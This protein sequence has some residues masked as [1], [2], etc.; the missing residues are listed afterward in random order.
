MPYKYLEKIA[1]ADIAFEAWADTIQ[2]LFIA[3]ADALLNVMVEDLENIRKTESKA[4]HLSNDTLDLL[5]FDVLQE[6]IYYKDAFRL[7]LKLDKA[8]IKENN[9]GFVFDGVA[10]G[11]KISPQRHQLA[12]DVKAVTFYQFQLNNDSGIWRAHVILDI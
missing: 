12:A 11:E 6:I 1:T 7:F 9:G 2:E 5:L 8:E 3:S 10:S 4:L